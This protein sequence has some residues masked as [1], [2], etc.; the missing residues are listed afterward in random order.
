M[1]RLLRP[2][3]L[4]G[5]GHFTLLGSLLDRLSRKFGISG[6]NVCLDDIPSRN[7]WFHL[8]LRSIHSAEGPACLAFDAAV[9][10]FGHTR[11]PAL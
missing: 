8:S 11:A 10:S 3:R 5:S 6:S 2:G 9:W 4:P 7:A 1:L